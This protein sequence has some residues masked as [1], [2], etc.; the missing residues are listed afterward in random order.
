M[1]ARWYV[2]KA[3]RHGV[4]LTSWMSGAGLS[5]SPLSVFVGPRVRALTYHRI[6]R[7]PREPFCVLP[8]VFEA[9]VAALAA[10][11]LA[12]SLD[13]VRGFVAGRTALPDGACLVTIDDGCE[14]TLSEALPIL[15]RHGVPAVA[16]VSASLVGSLLDALPERYL[17]WDELRALS[18]SGLIEVG[19]HACTHRSLGLMPPEEARD[20]ARRSK[21]QIE[22]QL[23]R[24]CVAFAY[25]FGTRSDFDAVTERGLADAGYA[26]AFNSMHGAIRAGADPISLPRIKVEGGEGALMFDLLRRGAMDAWRV[27]DHT[28]FRLQR[29]REEIA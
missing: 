12:A 28:L 10:E 21:E 26:I 15:E 14:S 20:E 7:E 24:A 18:A 5:R 25:P 19:S 13:D 6:G 8:E 16:F 1:S 17:G 11:G 3:A 9:H 22:D 2:K 27:V 4:A 23:G 29:V